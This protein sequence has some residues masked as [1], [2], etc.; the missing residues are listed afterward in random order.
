MNHEWGD[1]RNSF[2]QRKG[3]PTVKVTNEDEAVEKVFGREVA[4]E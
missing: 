1:V 2:D 3:V 4:A